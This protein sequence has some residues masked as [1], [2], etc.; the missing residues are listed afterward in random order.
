M[1]CFD[2]NRGSDYKKHE[3]AN[4]VWA[5]L[6]FFL[7]NT[8][9]KVWIWNLNPICNDEKIRTLSLNG[10]PSVLGGSNGPG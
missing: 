2:Y 10:E 4:P 1:R 7:I 8:K 5:G 6:L 3:K 9:K